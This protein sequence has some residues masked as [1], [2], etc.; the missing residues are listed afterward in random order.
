M[1]K[2]ERDREIVEE[3]AREKNVVGVG[4]CVPCVGACGQGCQVDTNTH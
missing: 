1:T 2:I 4:L 3:T